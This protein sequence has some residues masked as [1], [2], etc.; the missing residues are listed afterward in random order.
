M[1]FSRHVGRLDADVAG[2][3]ENWVVCAV[4]SHG[5]A[6]QNKMASEWA[7][8]LSRVPYRRPI[9]DPNPTSIAQ[10]LDK[11]PKETRSNATPS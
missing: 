3:A 11:P 10:G 2:V 8:K 6:R 7:G 4:L 1:F 5:I 9:L